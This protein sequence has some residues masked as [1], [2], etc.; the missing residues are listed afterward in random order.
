MVKLKLY[1]A[2]ALILLVLIVVLQNTQSVETR[3]LFV[4]VVMPRAALLAITFLVGLAA[5]LLL[6]FVL[7]KHLPKKK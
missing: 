2:L 7:V 4:S 3:F 1:A 6:S 5:G